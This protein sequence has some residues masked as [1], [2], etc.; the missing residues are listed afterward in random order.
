M[1]T[2]NFFP[3]PGTLEMLMRVIFSTTGK[4]FFLFMGGWGKIK[5]SASR[6]KATFYRKS[7]LLQ[8]GKRDA[9]KLLGSFLQNV[10]FGGS[11]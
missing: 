3:S 7:D 11:H 4:H 10:D 1:I 2:L 8:E 9:W 6:S 5:S